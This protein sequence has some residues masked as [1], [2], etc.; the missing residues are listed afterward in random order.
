[1]RPVPDSIKSDIIRKYLEGLSTLQISQSL[2]VS[3]GT[4]STVTTEAAK[5]DEYF[6]YMREIARKFYTENLKFPHVISAIR[7]YYKIKEVGLTCSF[8]ENFLESTNLETYRL[9][10]EHDKFLTKITKIL[11]FEKQYKINLVDIPDYIRNR[12]EEV[13][14]NDEISRINQSLYSR[15]SVKEGE[16]QEYKREKPGLSRA[17][18]LAAISLPTHMDWLVIID[19]LFKK[20]SRRGKIKIDPNILYKKLN[21]IYKNPDKHI[22]IIKQILEFPSD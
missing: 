11:Q 2:R 13:K 9:E 20:A 3:V 18:D 15:Y 19:H 6:S 10:I 14:I 5:Q 7:L 22:D 21:H 12:K 1:M 16:I 8:F 4:V 17:R